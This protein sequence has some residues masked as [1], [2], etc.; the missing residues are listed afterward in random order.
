MPEPRVV[1]VGG[2]LSGLALG[3]RLRE[4]LKTAQ[5]TILEK[6]PTAGGNIATLKRDGFRVECG[7]NGI[8]DA[9]PFTLQLCR[10]LGLAD[11]LIVASEASRKNRYLFLN[12]KLQRL[13]SSVASFV[14]SP[15]LSMRAKVS[16]LFEKYRKRP[17][18]LPADESIA[19][20]AR[21]R[22]GREVAAVLADAVVTGIHAGDPELLSVAA[23]FPRLPQFER[24]FGSVMRGFTAAGRQR[25]AEAK[26]RGEEPS[27]Q[28][29]WSFREGLQVL[30][31]AFRDRFGSAIVS[32]VTVRRIERKDNAWVVHGDGQEVW[33]A[34]AVVLTAHAHEQAA[35]I[36]SVDPQLAGE[37]A[38]IPYSRV[39]VVAVGFRQGDVLGRKLDG[40]GFIA[41][42]NTRRDLLGVQWCSSIFPERAPPGMVLW[43][44]LCGGWHRG[45][46][47]DWSDQR[48]VEAARAELRHAMGVTAEP[49]FSHV[50]RWPAA[51][52]QY[53]IGHIGRVQ[54]IES[55]VADLPGLF[56][57]G[58]AYHGVAM[59]DCTEQALVLSER[60]ARY[61]G[62]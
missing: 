42:Q 47:I 24:E 3:Y 56:V 35:M 41:P 38:S 43:R 51:I 57:G 11:R 48:L 27:P 49:V 20:F 18:H 34:D 52:P 54:R 39:A 25:R 6:R 29:L 45:E 26:A 46:M 1:I 53:L 32:G 62:A 59:N 12:D 58:N 44:A 15:L 50:V 8:F 5:I 17:A 10:D 61:F 9:K 22:A 14:F 30:V 21:R 2:G 28:R 55:G 37:M 36:E 7:P 23:A 4:R 33:H 16:L 19:E 60:L 40:F 13:P 31:D